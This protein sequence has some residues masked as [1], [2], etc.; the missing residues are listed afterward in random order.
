MD[1]SNFFGLKFIFSFFGGALLIIGNHVEPSIGVWIISLGG[2]LL[3]A[4]LGVDRTFKGILFY[5]IVGL[6]WGIFGSQ[7][8]HTLWSLPQEAV[9]FFTSMFG[10]EMTW[11]I[12]K[13]MK[14]GSF[15]E[16]F[17]ELVS[18]LSPFNI[19]KKKE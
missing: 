18:K 10:G 6:G 12:L 11:Y 16:F 14:T 4:S 17:I 7:I 5:I 2:T 3:T 8:I 19:L 1:L 9:C 15:G 13:S